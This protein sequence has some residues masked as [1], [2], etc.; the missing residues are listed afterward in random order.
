M[1]LYLRSLFLLLVVAFSLP[2]AA[3]D[4][5]AAY[6]DALKVFQNAGESGQFFKKSDGYAMF[7]GIGKGG[8][9][10]GRAHG[11]GRVYD[12]GK[13]VGTASMTQVTYGLQL[14]GQKY[15]YTPFS[16]G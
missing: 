7:P 4:D 2:L 14:G 3:D 6:A 12:G 10:I 11:K 15:K 16:G 13:Q 8:I 5:A 9:G 1:H